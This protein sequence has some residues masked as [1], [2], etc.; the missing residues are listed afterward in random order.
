MYSRDRPSTS[1]VALPAAGAACPQPVLCSTSSPP[2]LSDPPLALLGDPPLALLG[3][4]PVEIAIPPV[5]LADP[6]L[7]VTAPPVPLADPPLETRAPPLEGFTLPPLPRSSPSGEL[8]PGAAAS[9]IETSTRVTDGKEAW[10]FIGASPSVI[11]YSSRYGRQN[12]PLL[13]AICQH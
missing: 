7:E 11:G 9:V 12:C 1:I 8:Q 13:S 6:P 4:P 2:V 3:V 5:P 10:I